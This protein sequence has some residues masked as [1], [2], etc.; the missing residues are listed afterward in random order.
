[1]PSDGSPLSDPN[2]QVV[3]PDIQRRVHFFSQL[4][5]HVQKGVKPVT[6]VHLVAGFGII[7]DFPVTAVENSETCDFDSN[8]DFSTCLQKA[9]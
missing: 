8:G 5:V 2:V 1:M 6:G 9:K 4:I 7:V 3:L